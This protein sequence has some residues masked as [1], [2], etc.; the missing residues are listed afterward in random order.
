MTKPRSRKARWRAIID[1]AEWLFEWRPAAERNGFTVPAHL[2]CWRKRHRRRA[3][4]SA[5]QLVDL[6]GGQGNLPL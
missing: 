4:I 2:A 6:A 5:G 3:E 1:G